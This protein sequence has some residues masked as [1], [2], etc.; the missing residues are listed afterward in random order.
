M[1][2]RAARQACFLPSLEG[3]ERA[4]P[5]SCHLL[6]LYGEHRDARNAPSAGKGDYETG[7][8]V[9]KTLCPVLKG[10]LC[11]F[12]VPFTHASVETVMANTGIK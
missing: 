7:K 4:G 6:A 2:M 1:A 8:R 5:Q 11:A 12:R 9:T 10:V 3:T